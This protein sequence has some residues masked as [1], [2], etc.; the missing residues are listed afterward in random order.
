MGHLVF[1]V[2]HLL[3]LFFGAGALIITIPAHLIY[4]AVKD[5]PAVQ[6]SDPNAPDPST[7]VRCPDCREL[8]RFDA[9]KCKHC[10]AGLIASSPPVVR[11]ED[12]GKAAAITVL[13]IMV[14]VVATCSVMKQ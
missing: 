6:V 8:V 12:K 9:T 13:V 5:K 11:R 14:V 3:A 10:G 7:H 4:A 2:L 1:F